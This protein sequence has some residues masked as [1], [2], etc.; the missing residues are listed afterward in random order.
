MTR[1]LAIECETST[2]LADLDEPTV[3]GFAGLASGIDCTVASASD[4][5]AI[6]A[7]LDCRTA[8]KN[9]INCLDSPAR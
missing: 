4:S 5:G 8:R 3:K 6:K 7:W 2:L 1:S 9:S